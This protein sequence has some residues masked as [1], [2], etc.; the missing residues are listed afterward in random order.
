MTITW[1]NVALLTG[2]VLLGTTHAGAAEALTLNYNFSVNINSGSLTGQ[3]FSGS[4]TADNSA[5]TGVGIERLNPSNNGLAVSFNFNGTPLSEASDSGYPNFPFVEFNNGSL[6]GLNWLPS[7]NSVPVAGIADSAIATGGV[8]TG[9]NGGNQF[10]Y[11]LSAL[12]GT[13]T[14]TGTV[15]YTAIPTPSPMIGLMTLGLLSVCS[16]IRRNQAAMEWAELNSSPA[17]K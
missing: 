12:G 9:T 13:G 17:S 1:Q 11:D 4:F 16:K 2:I 10:A 8:F 3:T 6:V 5:L 15:T 14:G 7:I